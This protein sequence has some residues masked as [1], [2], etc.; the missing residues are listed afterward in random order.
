M[1]W[2]VM[3]IIT[4]FIYPPLAI[5][6]LLIGAAYAIFVNKEI[7]VSKMRTLRN[8][9]SFLLLMYSMCYNDIY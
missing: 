8:A 3:F 5:I 9:E 7:T 2:F 6:I 4:L 1:F